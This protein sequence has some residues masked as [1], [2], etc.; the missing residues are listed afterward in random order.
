MDKKII[1]FDVVKKNIDLASTL[2]KTI[3]EIE[4]ILDIDA[5]I[6]LA[7]LNNK[8]TITK[9]T[10]LSHQYTVNTICLCLSAIEMH[11]FRNKKKIPDPFRHNAETKKITKDLRINLDAK[12]VIIVCLNTKKNVYMFF[13]DGFS[14][15]EQILVFINA[16][17]DLNTEREKRNI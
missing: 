1:E 8:N 14:R 16:L 11:R 2:N 5:L 4:E 17:L 3:K 9:A 12:G 13:S 7:V 10:G 15:R 6:I